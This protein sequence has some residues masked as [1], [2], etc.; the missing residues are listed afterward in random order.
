MT[1]TRKTRPTTMLARVKSRGFGV[2]GACQ[3]LEGGGDEA[4]GGGGADDGVGAAGGL[5]G[6]GGAEDGCGA[7][8]S[9]IALIVDAFPRSGRG[10]RARTAALR[11]G[12]D[13]GG[14]RVT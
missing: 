12:G 10:S 9:V 2:S 11:R 13:P 4:E 3:G 7:A 8:R 5:Q 6:A 14:A 1:I